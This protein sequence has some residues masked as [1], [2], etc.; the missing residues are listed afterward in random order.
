MTPP[1]RLGL[2][3]PGSDAGRLNASDGYAVIS[4]TRCDHSSEVA[5]CLIIATASWGRSPRP[6]GS[7]SPHSRN[8]R[9]I[10]QDSAG[11]RSKHVSRAKKYQTA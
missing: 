7:G 8:S 11:A 5:Q 4:G 9:S 3:R 1:R 10:P 6:A 2:Q